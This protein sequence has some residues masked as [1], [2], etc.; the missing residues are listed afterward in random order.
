MDIRLHENG[1][2]V[3]VDNFD[4]KTITQEQVNILA[5]YL[6][7][8]EVVVIKNQ[9]F[10]P[11]DEIRICEMFGAT[12]DYSN[13]PF[14]R[15][16]LLEDAPELKIGRVTGEL[17]E[18]GEPGAFGH[19]H[20]LEWHCNRV[21]DVNRKQLVWLWGE[22]GTKGSRTSWLNNILSWNAM[23]SEQQGSLRDI[24]LNVGE[25][26]QFT[27]YI[28]D[29]DA[30][31]PVLDSYRPNLVYTNQLGI[32]GLFFSW[33]QI[34]FIEGMSKPDGRKFIDDLQRQVEREEF[35]YHH[36]W[37]DGDLV[38]SEQNLSIHKRW[39]FEHINRRVL[40]RLTMGVERTDIV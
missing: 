34:H 1:W 8:N 38:I 2:T 5:R 23:S 40:H 16:F 4:M 3:F 30:E 9:Q 26:M 25:A 19:V 37:D 22:R 18:H 28:W 24:K 27:D 33:R 12:E 21:S 15:S 7:T 36:D 17:N 11:A 32:T 31:P 35:M 14:K 20:E 10:T 39:E 29:G 6:L 13:T